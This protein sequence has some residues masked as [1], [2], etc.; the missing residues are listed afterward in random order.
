MAT[1]LS[2]LIVALLLVVLG[3][4]ADD[5]GRAVK[6]PMGWRSWNF[7]QCQIDQ[8]MMEKAFAALAD[9]SRIVDG[10][11]TSLADLGYVDA[12]LDDCWQE[13]GAYGPQKYTYHNASGWPQVNFTRFPDMKHMVDVAHSLG[14][15]AGF[16]SNNCK[17]KDH[18][19]DMECFAS[20][21]AATLSWG[22]DSIK[23]DGCGKEENVSLWRAVFNTTASRPIMIENCHNGPNTPWGREPAQCPFHMYRSSTD[24]APCWGSILA[25][26]QTAVPLAAAGLSYPGCWAYPDMLEVMQ[27]NSQGRMPLLTPLE[28]RSHFG[29]WAIVSSPLI[30]GFDLSN[31][32]L[33]DA[34]WPFITNREVIAVNQQWAGF[35]GSIFYSSP[36]NTTFTPCGWWLPN[37][38]FPSVQYLYKP[39]PANAM[40]V[41][42]M[43]NDIK[44]RTLT[45]EFSS[46]PTLHPAP[47]YHVRDLWQRRDMGLFVHTYSVSLDSHDSAFV[48]ITPA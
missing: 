33:I 5:N 3:A 30:L 14:L 45:L 40:A 10:V 7:H 48:L 25:N 27:T 47:A 35:S 15:R 31:A 2:R 29:L 34:A 28:S 39:Q 42:L 44:Q 36:D 20:D 38:S 12:G 6:P 8:S 19:T 13:C 9:R 23:L 1:N 22:F 11:P 18:C 32:S 41:I 46:V 37:C 16:Y 43:N 21:V 26:L 24:I 4:R 17:C